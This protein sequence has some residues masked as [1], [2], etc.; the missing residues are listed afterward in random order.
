[1]YLDMLASGFWSRTMQGIRKLV[2]VEAISG[3]RGVC[4]IG[5][6]IHD[7]RCAREKLT[8]KVFVVSISG[9]EYNYETVRARYWDFVGTQQP[10]TAFWVPS[11]LRYHISEQR[12][13]EF[14]WLSG[15]SPGN[16]SPDDIIRVEVFDALTERLARLNDIVE[17]VN[18]EIAHAATEAS[19]QGRVLD[20]WGLDDAKAAIKELAQVAEL[21][22]RWFCFE[23]IGTV[24]PTPQ[25]DQFQHLNQPLFNGDNSDLHSIWR[26]LDSE[27]AQWHDVEAQSLLRL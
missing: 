4:S 17:H 18:V 27:I 20:Q 7:A 23:G 24:L 8:R 3:P 11:D 16:S 9:S 25:F 6:L 14:D 19:R 10:G 2:E 22:G 5:G 12:H 26:E 13:I 21:T 15:T 1:M